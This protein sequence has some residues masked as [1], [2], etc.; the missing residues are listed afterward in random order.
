[1]D[2]S[3]QVVFIGMK[4]PQKQN[5]PNKTLKEPNNEINIDEIIR[6][7][8]SKLE[9]VREMFDTPTVKTGGI[10]GLPL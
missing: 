6:S 8:P 4:K 7:L 10:L 5:L 9:V 3:N 1:M 2:F